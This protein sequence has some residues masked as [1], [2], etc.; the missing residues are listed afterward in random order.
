MPPK[1]RKARK[2]K[3]RKSPRSV[4]DE[5]RATSPIRIGPQFFTV[6]LYLGEDWPEDSDAFGVISFKGNYIRLRRDKEF[7][8]STQLIDTLFHEVLHGCVA[9]FAHQ[10]RSHTN[11]M[12]EEKFIQATE[13]GLTLVFMDNPKL[14]AL[15]V[16]YWNPANRQPA[17]GD[18]K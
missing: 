14:L 18:L 13:A 4:V 15:F 11:S 2:S 3:P 1:A 10:F 6:E 12:P 9:C 17:E 16:K 5:I 7:F 8:S